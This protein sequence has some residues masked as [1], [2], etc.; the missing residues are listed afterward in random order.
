MPFFG[1]R[2]AEQLARSLADA[3][4]TPV[5]S[6]SNGRNLPPRTRRCR[7]RTNRRRRRIKFRLQ[8]TAQGSQ[9]APGTAGWGAARPATRGARGSSSP[10]R[11]PR[12]RRRA[13]W[14][15]NNENTSGHRRRRPASATRPNPG[16]TSTA[17]TST[18]ATTATSATPA[19][20]RV[21][22]RHHWSTLAGERP[23]RAGGSSARRPHAVHS[24]ITW[25]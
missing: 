4:R 13:S 22:Q 17:P 5:W 16:D 7:R 12:C 9:A 21:V 1:S 6:G 3:H 10:P 23:C 20:R 18:S 15:H 11:A 19:A 25:R 14:S 24:F 8:G 2:P